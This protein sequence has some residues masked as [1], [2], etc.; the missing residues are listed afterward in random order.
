MTTHATAAGT[1]QHKPLSKREVEVLGLMK[2]G[3]TNA[4]IAEVLFISSETV[5][6][7]ARSI[8]QKLGVSSRV[9]AVALAAAGAIATVASNVPT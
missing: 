7:H 5:K 4:E 3:R 9:D 6:T 2:D 8:F 1:R